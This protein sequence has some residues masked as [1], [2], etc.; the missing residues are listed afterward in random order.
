VFEDG[1]LAVKGKFPEAEAANEGVPEFLHARVRVG[2]KGESGKRKAGDR[3]QETENR[4]QKT[5]DGRRAGSEL[6]ARH[7]EIE[8]PAAS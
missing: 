6:L 1:V 4:K 3:R 5:D 7:R 8:L 2:G